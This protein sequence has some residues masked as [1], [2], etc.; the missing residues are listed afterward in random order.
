M[1]H[2][3]IGLKGEGKTRELLDKVNT[4]IKNANGNIVYLDINSKHMY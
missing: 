2:L 4:E 1:V 3:I